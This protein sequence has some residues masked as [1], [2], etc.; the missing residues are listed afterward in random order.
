MEP[1]YPK[2]YGAVPYYTAG[3]REIIE[4]WRQDYNEIRPQSH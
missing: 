3:A 4:A 2:P 1:D